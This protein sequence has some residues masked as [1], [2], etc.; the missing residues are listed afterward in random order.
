ALAVGHAVEDRALPYWRWKRR[1]VKV[2]DGALVQL[3]DTPDDLAQYPQQRSQR[4]GTGYTTLRLVVVLAFAT[5]VVLG[6]ATGPYR[7]KG[8]GEMSLLGSLLDD[9]QAGDVLLGD[10]YYGCYLLLAGLPLRGAD[11]CFRLPV[12]KEAGLASATR[13]GRDDWL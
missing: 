7:G 8:S 11:G 4:P 1:T 12:R 6:A 2:V 10:R 13:V 9:I 5:A 3:P